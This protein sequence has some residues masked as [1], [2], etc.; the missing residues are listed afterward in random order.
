V[1]ERSDRSRGLVILREW[2]GSEWKY[3]WVLE[4]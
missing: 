4:F 2:D 1:K 3:I